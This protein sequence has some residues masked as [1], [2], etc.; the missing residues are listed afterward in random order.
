MPDRKLLK[1][2]KFIILG[3][4][5]LAAFSY[6]GYMGFASGATYYYEVD[7]FVQLAD[8]PSG[9]NVRVNGTVVAGSLEQG[10]AGAGLSFIITQN[11][12]NLPVHYQGVVPDTFK[13]GSE[14]TIE[15]A[16][17]A[18]GIFEAHTLI[19]KCA[20]KYEPAT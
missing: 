4:V 8:A 3:L 10:P 6:L 13:V 16:L 7:E 11:G 18:D 14:V 2:R 20:S 19:P 5:L 17:N 12:S 9:E 1:H 15:G